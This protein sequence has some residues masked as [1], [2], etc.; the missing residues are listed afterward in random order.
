MSTWA[1]IQARVGST[2]LPGKVLRPLAGRPLISWVV[3]RAAMASSL[4]GVVVAVPAGP[5]D[6]PL[7][8]QLDRDG[9]R[10]FAGS[11]DDVL[12]RYCGAA[13]EVGAE[14]VV[15][16]TAD[17]PFVDPALVDDLVALYRS[18]GAAY[19]SIATGWAPAPTGLRR[20]PHGL[21]AEVTSR[22]ALEVARR[23]ATDPQDREHVTSF[24]WKRPERFP[25]ALLGA[26]EENG[27]LRLTVDTEEDLAFADRVLSVLGGAPFGVRQILD[28][29]G[30]PA[31]TG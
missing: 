16:L 30:R 12:D 5:P 26:D 2:R 21:D 29:V 24:I 14:H 28:V 18:S 19:A 1:I 8:E 9:V 7:R 23:E 4:N 11:E 20:Y 31:P 27:D 13:H 3:G 22:A 25:P 6:R 15:R 10:W 17:N